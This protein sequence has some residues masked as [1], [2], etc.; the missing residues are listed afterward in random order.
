VVGGSEESTNFNSEEVQSPNMHD[1]S[2]SMNNQRTGRLLPTAGL[3]A[4]VNE[5]ACAPDTSSVPSSLNKG[6][7]L[8]L[9]SVSK[10]DIVYICHRW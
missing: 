4:P 2:L 8:Y 9:S 3:S 6:A 7:T 1:S 10:G 5:G